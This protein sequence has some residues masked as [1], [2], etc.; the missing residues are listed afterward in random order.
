[1]IA[2]VD[3]S[4]GEAVEDDNEDASSSPPLDLFARVGRVRRRGKPKGLGLDTV[5]RNSLVEVL[6]SWVVSVDGVVDFVLCCCC[7]RLPPPLYLLLKLP[8]MLLLLLR[9]DCDLILEGVVVVVVEVDL[10]VG[11]VTSLRSVSSVVAVVVAVVES[12]SCVSRPDSDVW[13][14]GI[15]G[16]IVASSS[17]CNVE[18]V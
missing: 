14:L 18:D 9:L 5:P 15:L 8:L 6:V 12:S 10:E 2:G 1:M 13:E 17:S 4:D 11:F 16:A 3:V 7:L